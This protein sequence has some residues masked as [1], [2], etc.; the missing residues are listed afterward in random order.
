MKLRPF[1]VLEVKMNNI[2]I[3]GSTG[4]IG[5]QTLEV[6]DLNDDI[7][8]CA[9][10]ANNNA[11][12]MERQARKY[13]PEKIAMR[14]TEAAEKLKISLADTDIKVLGGEKGII[15][16]AADTRAD[17]VVTSVV[18]IS[19]LLPTEQAIKAGKNI[20]LAN[21]ETLVAAGS[22]IMPLAKENNV[23]ILPVDSEHS[24]VFQSLQG[25]TN[26]IKKIL[27]TA[28]GGPFFGKTRDE[29][30]NAPVSST[31]KHPNWNMGAKVTVDSASMMNKGFE[32]IEASWLFGVKPED[33]CVM[34]HRQSIVHSMVQFEDNAVIAQLSVPDMKLPIAY[35]LQ[36]PKRR[37][38]GMKELDLFEVQSLTFE[39]PDLESFPCLRLAFE[40]MKT[41]GSMPC[42]MNAANEI[43]VAKYLNEEIKFGEISEIVEKAM[44]EHNVI[45]NPS[46][47]DLIETDREVRNNGR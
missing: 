7:K 33:I 6:V 39:K 27:L 21:K 14:N 25:Y 11:E 43:A 46:L 34:V 30:Y 32:V 10:T 24:A 41:G 42:V 19:G 47:E 4:S 2:S 38:C 29:I 45:K 20:A 8:V 31:L 26:T 22:V 16:C 1:E 13:K 9:L 36:Y 5:T 23:K 12:L 37:Y 28:S 40:A 44:T 3:I 18:G 35:A 15:E 17:T